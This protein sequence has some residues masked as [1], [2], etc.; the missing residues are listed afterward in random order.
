[1]PA[2]AC[3]GRTEGSPVELGP[4]MRPGA[5]AAEP[6]AVLRHRD[7]VRTRL[8]LV[9][10]RRQI[11]PLGDGDRLEVLERRIGVRQIGEAID[12]AK[13]RVAAPYYGKS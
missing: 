4:E 7:R 11:E 8:R 9:P 5:R 3:G 12:D 13:L 6:P 1:M 2:I 10:S